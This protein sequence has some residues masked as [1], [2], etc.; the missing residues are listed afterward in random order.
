A[1]GYLELLDAQRVQ[2]AADDALA[3]AQAAIDTRA[4]ALYK[5][6]GGG[7]QACGDDARCAPVATAVADVP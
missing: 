2:L 6:L 3:Q 4:V 7:W 1:T 5:A